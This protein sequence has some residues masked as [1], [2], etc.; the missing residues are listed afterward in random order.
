AHIIAAAEEAMR[1]G[2]TRY[3][4]PDGLPELREAIVAKFKRENGLDYA[5]D[6]IS[7]GNG[8]KQILFNAFLGTLEAG[9]E[10]VVPAP[11]WVSSTDL[12]ILHGG[13]PKV[14]ACGVEDAFKITPERLEA[15]ITPKTRW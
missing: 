14:V 4:A 15:A 12:V 5:L 2:V 13:V 10:V 11:Y 1:R 8:A 7:I 6:E 9:D 3:T